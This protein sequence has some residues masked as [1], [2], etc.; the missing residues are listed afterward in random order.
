VRS[1]WA[2][3]FKGITAVAVERALHPHRDEASA[4]SHRDEPPE[5]VS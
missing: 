2:P 5:M 4:A 3:I 1:I